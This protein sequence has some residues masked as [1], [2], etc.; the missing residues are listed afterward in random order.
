MNKKKKR[1][2]QSQGEGNRKEQKKKI[3]RISRRESARATLW[4]TF[5]LYK[6][7]AFT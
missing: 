2:G 1:K 5:K 7:I 4:R 6:I 3:Q